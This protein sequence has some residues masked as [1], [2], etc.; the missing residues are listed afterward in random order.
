MMQTIYSIF[1]GLSCL[2]IT[3]PPLTAQDNNSNGLLIGVVIDEET[4]QG[5]ANAEIELLNYYPIRYVITNE[6]GQFEFRDIPLG[7]H[8]VSI[9]TE[10]YEEGLQSFDIVEDFATE[11][12]IRLVPRETG[13]VEESLEEGL[14]TRITTASKHAEQLLDAPATAYIVTE[15][16]IEERGYSSLFDVLEDIPEIEIQEHVNPEHVS[17]IT[18]RGVNG[19]EKLLILRDGMRINSMATTTHTM[20]KN[21]S[22]RYARRIEIILGPTSALYGADAFTGVVNIITEKG[23]DIQGGSV[24]SS[25]GMFHTTDNSFIGGIGDKDMS[26]TIGGNF[27]YT[28]GPYMPNYYPNDYHWF[29]SQYVDHGNVRVSPFFSDTMTIA[30]RPYHNRKMAYSMYARFNYKDWELGVAR[31]AQSNS[32]AIGAQPEY[33]P[34]IAGADYGIAL[35]NAY[36]NHNFYS[37]DRKWGLTTSL[38]WNYYE[39][40][41]HS[42]FINSYSSYLDAYKYGFNHNFSL[43]ETFN[44]RFNA[45]HQLVAGLS[46]QYTHALPKTGDLPAPYSKLNFGNNAAMHYL[47]TGDI[48]NAAY[49]INQDFYFF[50]QINAGAFVQYQAN[51]RDILLIT[52]GARFDYAYFRQ[53]NLNA[54]H[55]YPSFNPRLGI[56]VRPLEGLRFKLFYAEAFLAPSPEKRFDH[57]GSFVPTFDSTGAFNQF[58]S[59]FMHLPNPELNPEKMRS[60]ELYA[61]YLKG[62]FAFTLGGYFNYVEDLID[63]VVSFDERFKGIPVSVAERSANTSSAYTYGG[64]FRMDYK[65]FFGLKKETKVNVYAIYSYS[66]GRFNDTLALP[67][68]APH[69]AKLGVLFRHKW[70][71]FNVRGIYRSITINNGIPDGNGSIVVANNQPYVL[72]NIFTKFRVY[73]NESKMF[74][75]ELFARVRNALDARYYNLTTNSV[76]Y[77][78][79]APQNPITVTGGINV[80]FTK[81]KRRQ[82]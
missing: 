40:E 70:F 68:S 51:I 5:I 81:N 17:S 71:S 18:V 45:Q 37:E 42:R 22:V 49:A 66:D 11:V 48:D 82:L 7:M 60:A 23:N 73:E 69:T 74:N 61:N 15:K 78:G 14:K 13:S 30:V 8:R 72:L 39:L 31:N 1:I 59:F 80:N 50:N 47:G 58:V 57:Y 2:W 33:S 38:E 32:S 75:I 21:F 79:A 55:Q 62:N 4:G 16:D 35:T 52:L 26:V 29:T 63:N 43:R 12:E 67:F 27:Y 56:V 65:Q 34:P 44:Y 19:N 64:S 3:L 46:V 41:N 54:I 6:Y 36:L 20:D 53:E 77:F 24:S 76:A 25:Y 9:V 28:N 10:D